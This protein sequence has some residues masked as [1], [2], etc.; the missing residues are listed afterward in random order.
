MPAQEAADVG[1]IESRTVELSQLRKHLT[2]LFGQ[3]GCGLQVVHL[4]NR[5]QS[6]LRIRMISYD[7]A[8]KITDTLVAAVLQCQLS[9]LRLRDVVLSLNENELCIRISQWG[10]WS[11]R[12]N[13]GGC[14]A[15]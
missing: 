6:I 8:R 11:T 1:A 3:N 12:E 13:G 15:G 7:L 10:D 4:R 5:S 2:M 9:R 14:N